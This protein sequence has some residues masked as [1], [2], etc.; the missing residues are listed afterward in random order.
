LH[1]PVRHVDA[2]TGFTMHGFLNIL[3]AAALAPR[4]DT[5][6]LARVVAEEDATAFTFDDASFSWRD[7]RIGVD[8]LERTRRQAFV[9]YGSCSFAEPIEDLCA[10]GVLPQ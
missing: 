9:A 4:L 5:A 7:Q 2:A 8:E 6:A 1:H 10:L 3:A